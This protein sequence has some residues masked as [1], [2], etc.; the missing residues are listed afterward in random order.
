LHKCVKHGFTFQEE[1]AGKLPEVWQFIRNCRLERTYAAPMPLEN[2]AA[3]LKLF[4]QDFR[5]FTVR[6]HNELAA[7][8]VAVRINGQTLYNFYPASPLRFNAFS[9]VI[10]LTQGLFGFC[11]Q[12][13]FQTL[14]LGT[15][16]LP[17]GPNFP[18]I[19]FKKHLGG[20]P[21]LKLTFEFNA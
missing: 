14:D 15:S 4:P 21:S 7:A 6:Q 10:L 19:A 1:P 17:S 8:T 16:N 3:L 5:L 11:R 20:E 12:E 18:L 13:N 2:L 9:P